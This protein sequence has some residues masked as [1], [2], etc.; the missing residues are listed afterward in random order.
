M[1]WSTA[2][3]QALQDYT[4]GRQSRNFPC[5]KDG[6]W[7]KD[8]AGSK[9]WQRGPQTRPP[10]EAVAWLNCLLAP[11]VESQHLSS[12]SSHSTSTFFLSPLPLTPSNCL[13]YPL[14]CPSPTEDW[15]QQLSEDCWE[16]TWMRIRKLILWLPRF[17]HVLGPV[18][19]GSCLT[20]SPWDVRHFLTDCNEQLFL[21]ELHGSKESFSQSR[22]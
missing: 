8:G 15:K 18:C 5:I 11:E 13:F 3:I 19:H 20:E 2:Q 6:G 12:L 7:A 9:M 21:E 4:G 17:P 1:R 14:A 16:S 22:N 10:V